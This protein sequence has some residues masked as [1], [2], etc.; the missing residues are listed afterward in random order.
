MNFQLLFIDFRLLKIFKAAV[1]SSQQL[2]SCQF[3]TFELSILQNIC[4]AVEFSL[5]LSISS[6]HS[7]TVSS[8]LF[9]FLLN[10]SLDKKEFI[11]QFF[12]EFLFEETSF[13]GKRD[14]SFF[15]PIGT[16]IA[17]RCTSS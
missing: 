9:D 6:A 10:G 12:F 15:H 5:Q 4:S 1:N 8:V 17:N 7:L 14:V 2:L 11:F 3:M 13:S 16:V